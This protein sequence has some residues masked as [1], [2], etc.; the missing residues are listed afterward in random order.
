MRKNIKQIITIMTITA[1]LLTGCA[2]NQ[3]NT[4]DTTNNGVTSSNSNSTTG[5]SNASIE[6]ITTS[7]TSEVIVDTEFTARDLEVGYEES[8]ATKVVFN[9]NTGTVTGNGAAFSEGI[10]KIN[11][12]G[13]YVIS[14]TLKDGQIIV[15][16]EE[17]DKIQIVLK[18]TNITSS[19]N[20]PIYV[21]SADKVF[22]T[23]EDGT[24]NTLTDSSEY[25]QTD[26]N[27]V[28]GAIFSTADITINGSGTLNINGN[29][30]HG[31]VSKDDIV[32]T[33]GTINITAIK[34]AINGKDS[35]RIKDG[36]LT[37]SA[38][39]GNGI[40]SKNDSNTT[41]GYV[42]IAGGK[43]TV[44]KS[45]EGIEGTIIQIDDGTVDIT[46]Q[47]DGLNAT[48]AASSETENATTTATTATVTTVVNNTL[49][50]KTTDVATDITGVEMMSTTTEGEV[51][52]ESSATVTTDDK[53]P[54]EGKGDFGEGFNGGGEFEVDSNAYIYING[55]VIHIDA[56]GDGI[57]SNGS[58]S[59]TG[60]TITVSGPTD[61]RNGALDYNGTADISGGTVVIA[62]SAGM[63][64]GFSEASTQYSILY[65]L[66]EVSNANTE[67]T[68]K[69]ENG[70]VVISYT[71]NKQ[72]QTIVI[73]TN[74][75]AKDKT[76]TLTSGDQTADITLT[77]MV[78]SN[79]QA[80]MGGQGGFGQRP[81]QGGMGRP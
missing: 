34:D 77:S 41:K 7:T 6:T 79:V 11:D 62:G 21:K 26:D 81:A 56:A 13:T 64:Q 23:L 73:S 25:I 78:T 52:A 60:G 53:A 36:T 65:S 20:A 38:E 4:T 74:E 33:S 32:I 1:T 45:Q 43:I 5:S 10:L 80:G 51:D 55:G 24:I 70:N 29:Y 31:I 2:A 67:I 61:S 12:E 72:Y 37:L 71:P 17:S 44:V 75:L 59:I 66:T 19:N 22:I 18:D 30:K 50:T 46:S 57:D 40:Q 27:T 48:S 68:L 54:R 14:G 35:V 9:G 8:T 3:S 39:T 16:A 76:Y 42:Y 69:D 49:D 15:E 63:A 47:D 28:D 58:I